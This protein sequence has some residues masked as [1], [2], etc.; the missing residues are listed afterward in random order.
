MTR[1]LMPFVA[2]ALGAAFAVSACGGGGTTQLNSTTEGQ[3]LMD[4]QRA[5]AEGAIT[6]QEYQRERREILRD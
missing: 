5:L 6:Q 3:Q 4:L 2:A 1:T